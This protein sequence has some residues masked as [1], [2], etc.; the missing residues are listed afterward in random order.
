MMPISNA[1]PTQAAATEIGAPI[2][3]AA[4]NPDAAP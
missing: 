3:I 4:A 2:N 1:F